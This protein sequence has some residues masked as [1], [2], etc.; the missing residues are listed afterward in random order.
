MRKEQDVQ[1]EA[2]PIG[3]IRFFSG[4][5]LDA[6]KS[7]I[8]GDGFVSFG[9]R[10]WI[11]FGESSFHDSMRNTF[12]REDIAKAETEPFSQKIVISGIVPRERIRSTGSMNDEVEY[13]E[14]S[15]KID[16]VFLVT[17]DYEQPVV[18]DITSQI[19]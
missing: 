6:L 7:H 16:R 5:H 8:D 13:I 2:T 17:G 1:F 3:Q 12:I 4:G 15:C 18:E 11:R 9:P 10:L 14:G 19:L